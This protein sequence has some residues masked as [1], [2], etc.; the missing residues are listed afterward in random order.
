MTFIAGNRLV[1]T[2]LLKLRPDQ[3]LDAQVVALEHGSDYRQIECSR[4]CVQAMRTDVGRPSSRGSMWNYGATYAGRLKQRKNGSNA[5]R[6]DEIRSYQKEHVFIVMLQK[7]NTSSRMLL[8]RTRVDL[9]MLQR[10]KNNDRR[11][12][13]PVTCWGHPCSL[14]TSYPRSAPTSSTV[15][16]DPCQHPRRSHPASGRRSASIRPPWKRRSTPPR[17]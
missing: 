4:A 17:G 14:S 16:P 8:L 5:L 7:H 3:A 10:S 6:T 15:R 9:Y 2:K 13:R 11:P 12:P 1:Y